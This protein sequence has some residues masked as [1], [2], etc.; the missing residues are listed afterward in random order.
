MQNILILSTRL[1]IDVHWMEP[2]IYVDNNHREGHVSFGLG[3]PNANF[4]K[5]FIVN[6]CLKT[7]A[8]PKK[9][10]FNF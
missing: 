3:N 10:A 9:R 1:I 2:K 5:Y 4:A 6:R 8:N 7:L